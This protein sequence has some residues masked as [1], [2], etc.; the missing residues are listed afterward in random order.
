MPLEDQ[1]VVASDTDGVTEAP[2][3]VDLES[4]ALQRLISEV[5]SGAPV[6]A[7]HHYDRVHNRHNR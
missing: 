2:L 1:V 5:R 4:V 3:E 7:G 6:V